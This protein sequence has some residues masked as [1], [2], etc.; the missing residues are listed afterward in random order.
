MAPA[1]RERRVSS[2][3]EDERRRKSRLS[4]K[5]ARLELNGSRSKSINFGLALV[6]L[7]RFIT[8]AQRVARYEISLH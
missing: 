5:K 4:D 2:S 6:M 8:L 3:S 1:K 7:L